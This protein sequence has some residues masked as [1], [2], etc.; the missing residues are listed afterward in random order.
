MGWWDDLFGGSSE[1]RPRP[2]DVIVETTSKPIET[3]VQP[4]R[5]YLPLSEAGITELVAKYQELYVESIS[6]G[7]VLVYK[8]MTHKISNYFGRYSSFRIE[9]CNTRIYLA[10]NKC[11]F[12]HSF[13]ELTAVPEM[14][15]EMFISIPEN[16]SHL[17]AWE[18]LQDFINNGELRKSNKQLVLEKL[19]LQFHREYAHFRD[20]WHSVNDGEYYI[21]GDNAV[22]KFED[23]SYET[24]KYDAMWEFIKDKD[25]V[26]CEDPAKTHWKH[27]MKLE[28]IQRSKHDQEL[29]EWVDGVLLKK[30]EYDDL[31]L[32]YNN[33]PSAPIVDAKSFMNFC[34]MVHEDVIYKDYEIENYIMI[35]R[36]KNNVECRK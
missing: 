12:E 35:I 15:A 34:R 11:T 16:L 8:G 1:P 23:W 31:N 5:K 27:F 21:F 18:L 9:G 13:G 28:A 4:E 6:K 17:S 26:K 19:S 3:V 14:L 24:Y 29:R 30:V 20:G 33:L 32:Q 2:V 22:Y 10:P 7:D 36:S 25:V